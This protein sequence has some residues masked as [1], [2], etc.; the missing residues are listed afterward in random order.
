MFQQS[1]EAFFETEMILRYFNL[2]NN[3]GI[4]NIVYVDSSSVC[5]EFPLVISKEQICI[6]D[7]TCIHKGNKELNDFII[8]ISCYLITHYS[9]TYDNSID[10]IIF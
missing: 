10:L 2:G 6:V 1:H 5:Y 4:D 3:E 8:K 7:T 9:M